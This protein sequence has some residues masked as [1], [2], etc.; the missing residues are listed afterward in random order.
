MVKEL[1]ISQHIQMDGWIED[2]YSW[3]DKVSVV[4][5][6]SPWEGC[7]KNIIEAMAKGRLVAVHNWPGAARLFGPEVLYNK[8]TEAV[9]LLFN[10]S[11]Q[12]NRKWAERFFNLNDKVDEL[13]DFAEDII[14]TKRVGFIT[15]L[16]PTTPTVRLRKLKPAQHLLNNSLARSY[17][18]PPNLANMPDVAVL[19]RLGEMRGAAFL[20]QDLKQVGAKLIYDAADL[21]PKDYPL[22]KQCDTIITSSQAKADALKENFTHPNIQVVNDFV[23]YELEE[24]M[25]PITVDDG[26][27]WFGSFSN[28]ETLELL[29]RQLHF[30]AITSKDMKDKVEARKLKFI[31]WNE[32][33]FV[34][35][36]RSAGGI[37]LLPQT[38]TTKSPNKLIT[39]I[40]AGLLPLCSPIPAYKKI[41][42]KAG[43]IELL[44]SDTT[45]WLSAIDLIED[46]DGLRLYL[47]ERLQH[48]VKTY[49]TEVRKE[50]EKCLLTQ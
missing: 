26:L 23:D 50:W 36:L 21:Y 18:A 49:P 40:M 46:S 30:T 2:I 43:C 31:E 47:I 17:I 3:L 37:C 39:A 20:I 12:G 5:S 28:I 4:V 16:S 29:P 48:Y 27:V 15:N 13:L 34:D 38:D 10:Q 32:K 14:N 11:E 35:D 42:E 44:C 33:T 22:M 24:P 7:P 8:P 25:P 19:S 1:G 41:C 9:N 45:A 6:S